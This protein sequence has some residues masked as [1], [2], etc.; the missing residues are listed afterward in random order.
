MQYNQKLS[1]T[2]Q[3]LDLKVTFQLEKNSKKLSDKFL[4]M[5]LIKKKIT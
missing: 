3:V 1:L 5:F 4:R 2:V